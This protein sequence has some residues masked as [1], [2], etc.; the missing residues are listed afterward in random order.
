MGQKK[1]IKNKTVIGVIGVIFIIFGIVGTIP[2]A[3]K[4]HPYIYGLFITGFLV[5][6]GVILIAWAFS[7]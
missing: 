2:L 6:L 5:I 1:P 3:L 4:G 7:D